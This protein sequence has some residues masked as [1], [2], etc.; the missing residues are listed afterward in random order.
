M[1]KYTDKYWKMLMPYIKKSLNR[2]YGKAYTKGLVQ[3]TDLVY[4]DMLNRADDIGADNPMASNTYECLLFLAVW[5]ASDGRISVDGLREISVDVMSA[6]MLKM[7]GLFING[8]K[9]NGIKRLRDMMLKN[10]AWLEKHPQYKDVS[11]DFNFDETRH[12]DGFYYHFTQCP[13]N[14]FARKEGYL[15]VLPVMC[16]IDHLTAKLMH[17]KLNREQTLAGGGS[18]CDYWFVGDK[19]ENPQ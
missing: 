6:P 3:K 9:K 7:A 1:M 18:M 4:R 5:K 16:D 2:R 17:L 15:E 11:W 12:K 19:A 8:N 10:A 14:N 13:L